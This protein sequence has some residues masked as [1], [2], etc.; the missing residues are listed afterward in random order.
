MKIKVLIAVAVLS[1]AAA[2]RQD[3]TAGVSNKATVEIPSLAGPAAADTTSVTASQKDCI[4][5]ESLLYEKPDVFSTY[6]EDK[7]RG[8]GVVSFVLD[9]NQRLDFYD[10]DGS[11]FGFLVLNDDMTYY[12]L[13]MPQKVIARKLITE[14]DFAAFDFDAENIAADKDY[15]IVYVNKEKRKVKK[16]AVKY[17]FRSWN[18]YLENATVTLKACNPLKDENGKAIEVSE[19]LI[20]TIKEVKDDMVKVKSSKECAGDGPF[21][22]LEAWVK[23]RKGDA[24][25]IELATCD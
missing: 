5:G 25:L 8:A 4:P 22:N 24:L 13:D 20:F 7:I 14:Y 3:H 2:C 18:E 23:W 1:V 19:D 6:T 11:V 12:T 9:I 21:K 17:T 10:M 16:S 15:L